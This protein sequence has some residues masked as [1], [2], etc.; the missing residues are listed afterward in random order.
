MLPLPHLLDTPSGKFM[1]WGHEAI[2]QQ[3]FQYGQWEPVNVELAKRIL[4]VSE[5]KNVLDVGAN[6]GPFAVPVARLGHGGLC[7]KCSVCRYPV[8]PMGKGV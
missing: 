1:V 6:F 7:W 2:A 3:L 4:A 5:F 8:C